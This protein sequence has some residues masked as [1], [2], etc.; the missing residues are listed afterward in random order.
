MPIQIK[1]APEDV[2]PLLP[3]VKRGA[4]SAKEELGFLPERVYDDLAISGRLLV[5]TVTGRSKETYA[6]HLMFGGI[7]PHAKV[8]QLFVDPRCRGRGVAGRL[9]GHLKERL[10]TDQW[11]SIKAST[12]L[13]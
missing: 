2:I 6:G 12:P 5:A 11:L 4:D 9:I 1:A 7:Y 13:P 3:F 10:T 8:F